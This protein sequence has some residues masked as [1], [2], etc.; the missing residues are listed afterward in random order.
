MASLKDFVI[1][2]VITLH[3]NEGSGQRVF[4]NEGPEKILVEWGPIEGTI[5][6]RRPSADPELVHLAQVK[7]VVLGEVKRESVDTGKGAK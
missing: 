3:A 4:N 2:S 6:I 1:K 7:Y 5:I